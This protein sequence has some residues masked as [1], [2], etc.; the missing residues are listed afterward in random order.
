MLACRALAQQRTKMV[1]TREF[2]QTVKERIERDP[3]FARAML[4][5]AA[6]GS[7]NAEPDTARLILRDLVNA[8][9]GFEHLARTTGKPSKSLHR[10]LSARGNPSMDNLAGIFD[11]LR[12]PVEQVVGL[13]GVE[14]L[15]ERGGAH[16]IRKEQGHG[17]ALAR[18]A[19]PGRMRARVGLRFGQ[20]LAVGV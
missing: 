12:H 2:R 10:M 16:D 9:I 14:I 8:T 5:E 13:L 18:Y 1:L 20:R 15:G 17:L 19:L 4:D 3:A 11:A 7:L 6:T